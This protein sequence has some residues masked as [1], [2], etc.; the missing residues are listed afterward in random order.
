VFAISISA[1]KRASN[2]FK[3]NI[4]DERLTMNMTKLLNEERKN[5]E[6]IKAQAAH[7]A[8]TAQSARQTAISAKKKLKQSRKQAKATKKI[9]RKAEDE[10]EKALDALDQAQ[11]RLEKLE[12]RA[13]KKERKQ[14]VSAKIR[15]K[16]NTAVRNQIRSKASKTAPAKIIRRGVKSKPRAKSSIHAVVQKAMEKIPVSPALR[17]E[18]SAVQTGSPADAPVLN[19]DAPIASS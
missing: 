19:P 10:A 13:R 5:V 15:E 14:K 9:A 6:K 12:R 3:R 1:Q 2:Y 16:K 17:V 4:D 18:S 11:T 8:R 7:A